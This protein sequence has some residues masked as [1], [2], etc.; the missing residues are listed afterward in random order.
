MSR[1]VYPSP[2]FKPLERVVV[3]DKCQPDTGQGGILGHH[4][5][6]IWRTPFYVEKSRWG[7]S[8]WL[9]IV[10]TGSPES[11]C[12]ESSEESQLIAT[13]TVDSLGPHLG[14]HFEISYDKD[15]AADDRHTI[16]GT[17]RVPGGFWNTFVFRK[18]PV[19]NLS[20]QIQ[21][22]MRF[23]PGAVAKYQFAV[24]EEIRIDH[25]YVEEAMSKVLGS[26][27]WRRVTG[28]RSMWF[29]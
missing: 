29:S 19:A 22:P 18:E 3:L 24:S 6:V 8:G 13:G 17:F 7:T 27:C 14:R 21:I 25:N 11:D 4:G 2:K 20:Y 9:Y 12:Y 10:H 1:S 28:P 5:T 16:T 26:E 15:E 23:Y